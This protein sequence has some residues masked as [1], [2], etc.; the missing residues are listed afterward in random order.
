MIFILI[1]FVH[2]EYHVPT[3]SYINV[4]VHAYIEISQSI[5]ISYMLLLKQKVSTAYSIT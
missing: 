2:I 5:W 1:L 3:T 4:V